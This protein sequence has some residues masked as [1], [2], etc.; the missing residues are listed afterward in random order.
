M[1]FALIQ[2]AF[3]SHNPTITH[4]WNS[5]WMLNCEIQQPIVFLMVH[6]LQKGTD[7]IDFPN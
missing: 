2:T 6:V 3:P 4:M 7:L 5:L 1:G